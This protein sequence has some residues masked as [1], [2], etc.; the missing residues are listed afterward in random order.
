MDGGGKEEKR[1]TEEREGKGKREGEGRR[2]KE[3]GEKERGEEEGKE[4]EREEGRGKEGKRRERRK[5]GKDYKFSLINSKKGRIKKQISETSIF[6][7]TT[8][9]KIKGSTS[10]TS[11][12]ASSPLIPTN[13]RNIKNTRII[14]GVFSNHSRINNQLKKLIAQPRS[15]KRSLTRRNRKSIDNL[16]FSS[17]NNRQILN[18]LRRGGIERNIFAIL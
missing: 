2:G 4:R 8:R 16:Q 11:N 9:S 5:G 12:I 6:N 15:K 1:E 17:G 18:I 10:R 14:L 3:E 13:I 7:S